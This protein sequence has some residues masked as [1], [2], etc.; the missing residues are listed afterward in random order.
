MP[1]HTIPPPWVEG[2]NSFWVGADDGEP[3]QEPTQEKQKGGMPMEAGCGC[4]GIQAPFLHHTSFAKHRFK[5][6]IKNFKAAA[7]EHQ[8]PGLRAWVPGKI[9]WT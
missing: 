1:R 3:A 7:I 9:T 4:Q 2:V 6:K 5:E 8:L